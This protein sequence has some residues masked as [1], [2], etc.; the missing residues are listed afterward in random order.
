MKGNRNFPSIRMIVSLV[1]PLLRSKIESIAGKSGDD[2]SGSYV[3]QL[4]I[5]N[6]H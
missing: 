6:R 3:S 2:F 1:A 5:I 4:S